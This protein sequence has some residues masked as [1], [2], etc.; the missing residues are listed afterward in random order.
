MKQVNNCQLMK[1]HCYLSFL[2][3]MGKLNVS[4]LYDLHTVG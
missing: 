1:K 4:V 2:K 3:E